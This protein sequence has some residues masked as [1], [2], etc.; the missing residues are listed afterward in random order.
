MGYAETAPKREEAAD[1]ADTIWLECA[2]PLRLRAR[3]PSWTTKA[4]LHAFGQ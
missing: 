4:F 1:Q 3:Q 2:G